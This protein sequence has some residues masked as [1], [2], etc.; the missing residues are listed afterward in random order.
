MNSEGE[1]A[2]L[3]GHLPHACWLLMAPRPRQ[4]AAG[5]RSSGRPAPVR[6][7]SQSSRPRHTSP[8]PSPE[9]QT[10]CRSRKAAVNKPRG[11]GTLAGLGVLWPQGVWGVRLPEVLPCPSRSPVFPRGGGGLCRTSRPWGPGFPRIFPARSANLGTLSG[12]VSFLH[13]F[14]SDSDEPPN[15]ADF[16]MSARAETVRDSSLEGA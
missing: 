11:G 8:W 6:S 10:P 15:P 16:R 7:G 13:P 5:G 3:C 1:D 2:C 12:P 14:F 4:V 9:H